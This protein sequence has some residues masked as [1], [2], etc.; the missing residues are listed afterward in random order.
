MA[1]RS[2]RQASSCAS[3]RATS[4]RRP[5]VTPRQAESTTPSGPGGRF[6]RMLATRLKHSASATDDP[7][8]LCTTQAEGSWAGIETY[9]LEGKKSP[10]NLLVAPPCPQATNPE[11]GIYFYP[12]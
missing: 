7:P 9:D 11:T 5:S 8:N 12:H 3:A 2:P 1:S 10:A 6:S 4:P